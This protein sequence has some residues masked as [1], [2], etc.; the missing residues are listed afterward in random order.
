MPPR[1]R[2]A[3]LGYIVRGPLG[4][5]VWHHLQ[6]VIGLARLGHEVLFVEDSDDYPGCYDPT[7]GSFDR[8]PSYGL[9]FARRAFDRVGLGSLWGYHDAFAGRW[10]GPAGD[11][12]ARYCAGADVVLNLSG[13]NPL[14]PWVE[15]APA[16]VLVDTDPVFTQVRHLTDPPARDLAAAHTHF[17]T[18]G[19]NFGRPGCTI[20]DDGFPWRPTRQPVVLD[21]W[22]PGPPPEGAALTTVMQ[23]DSYAPREYAGRRFGMKSESFDPYFD[24]PAR[25]ALPLELAVGNPTA[26]RDRLRAA[27]WRTTDPLAVT[28]DPWTYQDYL[29]D[30]LG[31]FSVAK[32]GYVITRSGWF[33]ERTAA[34]LA[35]GRA[36]VVQDTGFAEWLPAGAGVLPFSTPDQ[37][38]GELHRLAA[39][40]AAHGRS[41][42]RLCE[43]FFDSN[44]VLRDL[45]SIVA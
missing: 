39:D 34:Y 44:A 30:S 40:P 36:V 12:A 22:K 35:T 42:R 27:G 45:L 21:A 28:R 26:P 3:V 41:A 17:F 33:S 4:G 16:R 32:H 9:E 20:P 23:W 18:F 43:E 8:D 37:A 24:L 11:R 13:M 19:E 1:L 10:Y 15:R 6:F 5:L 31:E 25:S 14:R 7:R 38:V 29:R 2:I